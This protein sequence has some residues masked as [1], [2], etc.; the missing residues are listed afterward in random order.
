LESLSSNESISTTA[1]NTQANQTVISP[2]EI[3]V[4]DKEKINEPE[5]KEVL[6]STTDNKNISIDDTPSAVKKPEFNEKK[7]E[8]KEGTETPV[9]KISTSI[10]EDKS[11]TKESDMNKSPTTEDNGSFTIDNNVSQIVGKSALKSANST[12]KKGRGVCFDA[13]TSFLYMCQYGD[14]TE[15][16]RLPTVRKYLGIPYEDGTEVTDVTIEDSFKDQIPISKEVLS[17][18]FTAHNFLTPLHIACTY[19]QLGIV[20]LL[21]EHAD[22]PINIQDVEGWTPLHCA[23]AEGNFDIV[24]YLGRCSKRKYFEK[25]LTQKT[26][27]SEVTEE[28]EEKYKGYTND[29]HIFEYSEKEPVLLKK[30]TETK[31]E[32][33]KVVEEEDDDDEDDEDDEDDDEEDDDEEKDDEEEEEE[34]PDKY[35]EICEDYIPITDEIYRLLLKESNDVPDEDPEK[36]SVYA[37]D[38]PILFDILNE[39][40]NNA[41]EVCQEDPTGKIIQMHLKSNNKFY[42]NIIF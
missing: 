23:C 31:V 5:K 10:T 41:Y 3:E 36:P 1:E 12:K 14:P 15:D 22:A 6:V 35:I 18:L 39:D 38:G 17:S 19:N 24:E 27:S 28:D 4:E 20:K 9:T 11:I 40:G 30:P 13:L 8:S 16:S 25:M 33:V 32:P 2:E 34:D 42:I 21:V 26:E 37:I 29:Y 7:E